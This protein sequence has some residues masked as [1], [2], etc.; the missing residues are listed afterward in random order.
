MYVVDPRENLETGNRTKPFCMIC[1]PK[2]GSQSMEKI[3]RSTFN[4]RP[5]RGMHHLDEEE[6]RRIYGQGGIVACTVRNPWDVM[7]SWYCY[8]ERD[9]RLN[10]KMTPEDFKPWLLRT[11]V[12]GNGWIE[13]GL[14][15][16]VHLCNRVFRFEHNLE[17]QLNNCLSDC[18]LPSVQF[19]HQGK[20]E[21]KHYSAYYDAESSAAVALRFA[22]EIIEWG[23]KFEFPS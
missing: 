12:A 15:Y 2:T 23:Y 8:S 20:T 9:P 22:N 17:L 11:I 21:H 19:P 4:A 16:G 5:V 7:V 14:F 6:C 3:L 10:G 1:H 18:G 13:K